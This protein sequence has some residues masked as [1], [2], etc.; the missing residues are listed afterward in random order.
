MSEHCRRMSRLAAPLLSLLLFCG[1]AA[2]TQAAFFVQAIEIQTEG[3]QL[4][5]FTFAGLPP[6]D[7]TGGLLTIHARGDYDFDREDEF[8][9]WDL[10]SLGIGSAAGPTIDV[11]TI[12]QEFGTTGNDT[13]W[14][15][16]FDISGPD[17]F[18]ALMDEMITISID[19]NGD[20]SIG[21]PG[22]NCCFINT[23]TPFVEVAFEYRP[24]PEPTAALLFTIGFGTI[25]WRC[26]ARTRRS[27]AA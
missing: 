24:I 4:F 17:L 26:T 18:T 23:G 16:S 3:G 11:T 8:L 25:G 12:I 9:I 15:Q 6:S 19:L 13:E 21:S 27:R 10:D 14:A 20:D 1:T 7:G 22:V 5:N 2:Q